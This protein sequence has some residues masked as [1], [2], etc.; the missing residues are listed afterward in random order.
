MPPAINVPVHKSHNIV[1]NE[2][3]REFRS[4]TSTFDAEGRRA[5]S[6]VCLLVEWFRLGLHCRCRMR[7]EVFCPSL[8]L[9]LSLSDRQ[10]KK[11]RKRPSLCWRA[12]FFLS[13]RACEDANPTLGTIRV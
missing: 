5:S 3:V 2:T 7:A 11:R 8:C 4:L 9:S 6:M 13:V 10:Q 12:G 1:T